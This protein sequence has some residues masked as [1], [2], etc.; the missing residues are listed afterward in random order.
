MEQ[1][2][3]VGTIVGAICGFL[4][5]KIFEM[6]FDKHKDHE[7]K[8]QMNTIAIVELKGEIKRLNDYLAR[9]DKLEKDTNQAHQRI[10]DLK[11]QVENMST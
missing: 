7:D 10:R 5:I 3:N 4:G 2:L 11:S 6:V 1:L 8:L 9:V